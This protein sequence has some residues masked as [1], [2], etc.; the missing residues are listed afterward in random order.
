MQS[1]LLGTLLGIALSAPLVAWRLGARARDAEAAAAPRAAQEAARQA[2]ERRDREEVRRRGRLLR[3]VQRL[4]GRDRLDD[5]SDEATAAANDARAKALRE[6]AAGIVDGVRGDRTPAKFATTALIVGGIWLIAVVTVITL[7]V[8]AFLGVGYP[9]VVA[10][11]V[12]LILTL[13]FSAVGI[14]IWD[15]VG[16]TDLLPFIGDLSARMRAAVVVSCLAII[17]MGMVVLPGLVKHRSEP[18]AAEVRKEQQNVEVLRA[19]DASPL[20]MAATKR[21][22]GAAED[23]RDTARALNN[24]NAVVVPAVEAATSWGAVWLGTLLVSWACLGMAKRAEGRSS[25]AHLRMNQR[26]QARENE[27]L[28]FVDEQDF[29]SEEIDAALPSDAAPAPNPAPGQPGPTQAGGTPPSNARPPA[30]P[31][32]GEP[33]RPAGDPPVGPKQAGER[34][35]QPDTKPTS[36]DRP[37]IWPDAF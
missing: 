19:Q 7:N 6:R 14:V 16:F 36:G 9:V 17:G 27:V 29:T 13:G 32:G 28:D 12:A 3:R 1:V 11:G 10:A 34:E 4:A 33:P 2:D 37:A 8:S 15:A 18:L 22:L 25:A 23:R 26:P 35:P 21:R 31:N 30:S 5:L 24:L 20:A